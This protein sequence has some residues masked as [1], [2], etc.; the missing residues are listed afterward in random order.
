MNWTHWIDELMQL[1]DASIDVFPMTLKCLG[2]LWL[3]QIANSS[4]HYR[5]NILGIWPRRWIGLP[6]IFCSPFLHGSAEHLFFNSVPL[7][8]LLTLMQL[9][10]QQVFI[11]VSLVIMVVSGVAVWL[12]GRPGIHVGASGLLMGYWG[13]LLVQVYCQPSVMGI[14]IA[15]LCLYYLGSLWLNLLPSGKQTSW[16]GHVFGCVAGGL[17]AFLYQYHYLSALWV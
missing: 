4:V 5:L 12:L 8:F 6:G 1:I 15:A 2:L 17:S 10:G 9:F 3:I 13:F 11:I 14:I 7:L 16:E